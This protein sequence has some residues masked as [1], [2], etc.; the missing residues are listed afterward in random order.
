M[1]EL[2]ITQNIVAIVVENAG[3][4]PVKAVKLQIGALSGVEVQAV[5]FCFDVCA[6]GTVVEGARLEVDQPP[7][8][9]R[10]VAC[11]KEIALERP[12]GICPCERRA[13]IEIVSG[14]ELLV[15]EMEL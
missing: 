10:C 7:G 15:K 6:K 4:R 14:E 13:R 3:G 5:R 11:D 8:L 2:S 12:L 1:H 9:G